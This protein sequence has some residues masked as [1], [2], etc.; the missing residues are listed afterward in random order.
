MSIE[1][2]I[3]SLPGRSIGERGE[4][5]ANAERMLASGPEAKR[6]DARRLLDALVSL[7]Q[8]ERAKRIARA[9][10]MDRVDLIV[11]AFMSRPVT[12]TEEKVI[13]VLLDNPGHRSIDL[14]AKLGWGGKAWHAHFGAMCRDRMADL[15]PAERFTSRPDV[16]FYSGLLAEITDKTLLFT[17]RPEAVEAFARIGLVAAKRSRHLAPRGENR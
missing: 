15:W 17:M 7:E 12:E 10:G 3:A 4:M 16:S 8:D 2:I 6:T 9:A 11:E 14:S 13:Q 1:K 5:R